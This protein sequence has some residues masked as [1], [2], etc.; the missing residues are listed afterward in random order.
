[1]IKFPQSTM[2]PPPNVDSK[3]W[4]EYNN[5]DASLTFKKEIEELIPA[6]HLR[7]FV[8]RDRWNGMSQPDK[9]VE[10]TSIEILEGRPGVTLGNPK[11]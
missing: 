11:R 4:R 3:K 8:G 1:M 7:R 2:Q 5:I 10:E 6:G 9:Q